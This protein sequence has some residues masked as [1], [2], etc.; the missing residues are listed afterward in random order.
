MVGYAA[1][2]DTADYAQQV[3]TIDGATG[4]TIS[5]NINVT[6]KATIGPGNTNTGSYAFVAGQ[7]NTANGNHATVS[8]TGNTASL[9]ATVG[10]GINNQA[11]GQYS[12]VAGGGGNTAVTQGSA[13]GGGFG[14]EAGWGTR[15]YATIGG[16][17]ENEV[18]GS[19]ATVP[20]GHLNSADG[21]YSF[22]A[23]YRAK[24]THNGSFVWADSYN[25]NFSSSAVNG[26]SVRASGGTWIFSNTSLTAGVRLW[27]GASAWSSVSNSTLVR[28]IRPVDGK[29]ILAGL[30]Q[31]P[32]SR[33][34][35]KAQDPSIE[36]IG[37][38]AQDFYAAFGLGEDDGC[39]ST[40]DADGVIITAVKE[41]MQIVNELKEENAQLKTEINELRQMIK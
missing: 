35:Y 21:E 19:Y 37:P 22:A 32:I 16:G 24:A 10:G 25:A 38:M 14:N 18:T 41:L 26:F 39:I 7:N 4:G 23:G 30:A 2:S 20:G 8:G 31:L 27:N 17:F 15:P 12:T 29:E 36:H 34:S 1:V 6:G 40:I 28:N 11:N 13:V 5:G 9:Q 3:A 33:W